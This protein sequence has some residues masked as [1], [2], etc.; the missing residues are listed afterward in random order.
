[1]KGVI[2]TSDREAA[3]AHAAHYLPSGPVLVEE[4]LAG[5]EVSLFFLSDGDHVLPL[6]PAQDFKRLRDG[7]EGP[8]TGGMGAYSP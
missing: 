4:F 8:N 7:D 2:V 5:P 3:L 6:S 1:G